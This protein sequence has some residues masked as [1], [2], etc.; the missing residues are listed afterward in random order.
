MEV[1]SAVYKYGV[2][3]NE[4]GVMRFFVIQEESLLCLLSFRNHS[5]TLLSSKYS[6]GTKEIPS[7]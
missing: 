4:Y 7:E 2:R 1:R 6:K 3:R 5:C